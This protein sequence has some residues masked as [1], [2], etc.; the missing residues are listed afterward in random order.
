MIDFF[1]PLGGRNLQQILDQ[2]ID[3]LIML[4]TPIVVIMILYAAFLYTT[5]GDNAKKVETANKTILYAVIGFG[6]LLI[7][8]GFIFIIKEFLGV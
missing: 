3:G 6:I 5:A 7:S 4:A 2:I 8:K 1:D